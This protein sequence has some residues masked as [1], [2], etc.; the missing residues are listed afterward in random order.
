MLSFSVTAVLSV[1]K[2][3]GW[4]IICI[5]HGWPNLDSCQICKCKLPLQ[6][7]V[8]QLKNCNHYI[9]V[10]LGTSVSYSIPE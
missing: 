4:Y 3:V 6:L 8:L 2:G 5:D 1:F 9:T 7:P 10:A